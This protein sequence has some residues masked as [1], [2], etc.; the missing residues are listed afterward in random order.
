MQDG[1]SEISLCDGKG[2]IHNDFGRGF[3]CT[4]HVELA[5]EWACTEGKSGFVNQYEID[6]T[7]LS[8]LNLLDSQYHIL[9][10]ITTL[11][12]HRSFE[13][14]TPI[15]MAGRQYLSDNYALSTEE[16]DIIRGYRADD[17]YFSFA[18]AFLNNTISV[19]QLGKAMQLGR[20]GEQ[21]VIKSE[22]AFERIIFVSQ[23][24]VDH[25][26]Y[27]PK[28]KIRDEEA[29]EEYQM[30]RQISDMYGVYL[31]D[32]MREGKRYEESGI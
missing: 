25:V 23:E 2:K 15:A 31:I 9:H 11:L 5:R 4:E 1:L 19:E 6:M 24:S 3:Y 20:L 27:Y 7:G 28:R 29:R 12:E 30:Q 18:R 10:W 21:I 26:V 17:S 13:I 8:V 32:L 14:S 22:K 16:Y